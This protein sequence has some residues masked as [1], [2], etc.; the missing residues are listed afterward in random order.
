MHHHIPSS[1]RYQTLLVTARQ[2]RYGMTYLLV[3][4][5]LLHVKLP[6]RFVDQAVDCALQPTCHRLAT[7][8]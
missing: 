6:Y 7:P 8:V 4:P 5:R 2:I 1:V 3:T